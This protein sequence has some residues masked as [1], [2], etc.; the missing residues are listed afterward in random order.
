[1][2]KPYQPWRGD[3]SRSLHGL[4]VGLS[5]LTL[6][7]ALVLSGQPAY[8]M[9]AFGLGAAML[10]RSRRLSQ[11]ARSREFGKSL[12]A[13]S[14]A[15]AL[16]HFAANRIIAR[17]NVLHRGLGDID[18]VVNARGYRLPIEIKAFRRWQQFLMFPG[19]RE[20]DA[21]AQSESQ[22]A[23]LGAPSGLLWLPQG[24][25][26]LLQRIFGVGRGRVKVVFGNE[27]ALFRAVLA[28]TK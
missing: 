2:K 23:A 8:G 12:E 25:P 17:A 13:Q 1:M 14:S 4:V 26:S 20:R 27:R 5:A 9:L 16:S 28:H 22:S 19:K 18:L 3:R 6:A 24:R 11:R 7:A 21:L 15:R 10:S